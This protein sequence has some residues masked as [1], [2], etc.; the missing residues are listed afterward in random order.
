M[1]HPRNSDDPRLIRGVGLGSAT[2]LNMIDMI[3]VGPFITMPLVLV[4]MGGP[5]ALLGWILGALLAICDGLVWAE[6]GAAMPGS[7][8]SY[9]YLREIYGPKSLGKMISFLFIWQLS[10]SAPLSI[11]SGAIGFAKYAAYLIPNL[12]TQYIARQWSLQLPLLGALKLQWLIAGTTFLALGVVLVAMFLLY[13]RIT[14]IGKI[15]KFLWLVV[16]ATIGWIIIAGLTHFNSARAFS[17]PPGAFSLSRNFWLGLGSAMLVATYDYWGAYNVCFL[18]GELKDP[19]KTIPR[20]VLLSIVLVGCLYLLMNISILGVVDWHEVIAAAQSNNKLYVF[21]IF[22]QRI[23]GSWAANLVTGL[24]MLTAFASVFSLVLGYSRVPYAAA[25]DGN[26]F[27]VFARVHPD[28]HFP[29]ISLLALGGASMLFCFLPLA[30]VISALVVIR[31]L[32]QFLLQAVGLIVLRIRRPDMPRPFRMWFYPVP[33]VL[34]ILGFLYVVIKRH[35]SLREVRYAAV[36]LIAGVIIYLVRSW[37]N[38]EWPFKETLP[39][40]AEMRVS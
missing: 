27:K 34:A 23:Y 5:Q 6:L 17:F 22:M 1:H 2:A 3:G 11:A 35:D 25:L 28:Y 13:R 15:S 10:F 38:R 37:R 40:P 32:L 12:E 24:I 31:I 26:Y 20:A 39:T 7:G 9:I 33:A 30:D 29:H 14:Q 36:V 8:G 19:G 21:S 4:A 16:M 18:G